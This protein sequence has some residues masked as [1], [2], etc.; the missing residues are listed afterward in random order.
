[1]L[2]RWIKIHDMHTAFQRSK[3]L[4]ETM[5]V[6]L[7]VRLC[8]CAYLVHAMACASETVFDMPRFP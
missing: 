1:M 2:V 3:K 8:S 6:P 5:S 4:G 7:R